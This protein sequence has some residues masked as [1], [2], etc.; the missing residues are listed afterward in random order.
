MF[1][2]G[3]SALSGSGVGQGEAGR[4]GRGCPVDGELRANPLG[5][6]V[7][8]PTV[9]SWR[10]RSATRN[11]G[12]TTTLLTSGTRQPT[13]VVGNRR[14][15]SWPNVEAQGI[16]NATQLLVALVSNQR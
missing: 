5:E 15:H 7:T 3:A 8:S 6:G 9:A 13:V 4:L 14:A 11:W 16:P 1:A 12:V 2:S 10:R